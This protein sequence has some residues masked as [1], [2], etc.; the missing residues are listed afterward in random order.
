MLAELVE[1]LGAFAAPVTGTVA[2][3]EERLA[4]AR[5]IEERSVT[6]PGARA[7][8]AV[9]SGSISDRDACPRYGGLA[10]T[11]QIGLLPLERNPK[12]GLWE[13][14]HIQTGARPQA[15][16]SWP[17]G[18]VNRWIVTEDTGLVFVLIPGGTFRMGAERPPLGVEMQET[19]E[20][21]LIT[22]V[23]AG[24]LAERM[25]LEKGDILRAIDGA[26]VENSAVLAGALRHLKS[27]ASVTA[28]VLRGGAELELSATA[29]RGIDSPNVD[30]DASD[31][32]S[33]VHDVALEPFFLSKYEMT[34]G[35]W[36]RFVGQNPSRYAAGQSSAGTSITAAHP[37]EQVSWD[38]ADG[39]LRK[40]GLLLPT[41][42]QW[43]YACRAGTGSVWHTGGVPGTLAGHANIADEG[44]ARF[45]SAGWNFEE[46][47]ADGFGVHAPVGSFTANA[48]GLYDVHGNVWELCRDHYASYGT[49]ARAG[50]GLRDAPGVSDRALRGG[51]FGNPAVFARSATR[52]WDAPAYRD[53]SLLGLRPSRFITE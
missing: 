32:E 49:P 7:A 10:I 45:Y 41:E 24:T 29:E 8:W 25:G 23:T 30:P 42:S 36:L 14:W 33:P 21:F 9:A 18:A 11:P 50:D 15:N 16:P 17:D 26:A 43:E 19:P 44:S 2:H 34:Q 20:G 39:V 37:V 27:G 4:F 22:S 31:K 35:Q 38:D 6:S 5:T 40:L 13:F 28:T 52:F 48:F 47:F 51:S 53:F 3:V 46:G 1:R 12:T